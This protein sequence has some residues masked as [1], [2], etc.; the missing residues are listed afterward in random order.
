MVF[1]PSLKLIKTDRRSRLGEDRLDYLEHI[2]VDGP[3]LNQWDATDAV[4]LWWRSCFGRQ[5]QDKTRAAVTPS[6]STTQE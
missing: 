2:A 1:F 6:T 3:P 5:G 4:Q